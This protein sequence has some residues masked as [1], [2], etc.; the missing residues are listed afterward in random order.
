MTV[1]FHSP[2]AGPNCGAAADL[3]VRI[4]LQYQA[5]QGGEELS[6]RHSNT[7][8][9]AKLFEQDVTMFTPVRFSQHFKAFHADAKI[10]SLP[11]A[12]GFRKPQPDH[13]VPYLILL[14]CA[15]QVI[16]A[17]RECLERRADGPR[18]VII[19]DD[20]ES[21]TGAHITLKFLRSILGDC[22][23]RYRVIYAAGSA[24]ANDAEEA[25]VSERA[26]LSQQ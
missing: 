15:Y 23:R 6:E 21:A 12:F 20:V 18:F 2:N 19:V 11:I 14:P 25:M 4:I 16:D 3:F 24:L 1:V 26:S 7:E 8:I 5:L 9:L 17:I 10:L 13:A 22:G